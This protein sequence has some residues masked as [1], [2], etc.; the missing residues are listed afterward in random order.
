M[1]RPVDKR[2]S[3]ARL[4][5]E[6]S[7]SERR[8]CRVIGADRKSMRYRTRRPPDTALR[9]RLRELA[10]ERRRFGY[11]RLYILLRRE[12]CTAGLTRIYRLYREEGLAVLRQLDLSD[13][14]HR[15]FPWRAP[16]SEC[17]R[18]SPACR[19]RGKLRGPSMSSAY[20]P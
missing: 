7:V 2:A 17:A 1:V 19:Q 5:Q 10:H 6:F 4:Q 12:G 9:H 15:H 3:V 16:I 11:R 8:A 14:P 18:L 20:F 13:T